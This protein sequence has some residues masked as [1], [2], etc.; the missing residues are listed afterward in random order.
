MGFRMLFLCHGS[1]AIRRRTCVGRTSAERAGNG[2]DNGRIGVAR[3]VR[4]DRLPRLRCD[5]Q[6]LDKPERRYH[7]DRQQRRYH[8]DRQHWNGRGRLATVNAGG[9]GSA[10]GVFIGSVPVPPGIAATLNQASVV[11]TSLP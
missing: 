6:C 4:L 9:G 11:T 7:R 8:H 1:D 3:A 5:N 10:L 2:H